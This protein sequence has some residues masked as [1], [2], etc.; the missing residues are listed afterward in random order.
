MP[1]PSRRLVFG[2]RPAR[3]CS[4]SAENLGT[5]RLGLPSVYPLPSQHLS[6]TPSGRPDSSELLF[7]HEDRM[8]EKDT[9]STR[10]FE[11]THWGRGAGLMLLH[12]WLVELLGMRHNERAWKEWDELDGGRRLIVGGRGKGGERRKCRNTPPRRT[13]YR[14]QKTDLPPIYHQ[15]F[16]LNLRLKSLVWQMIVHVPCLAPCCLFSLK[17]KLS[18]TVALR[19]NS[20]Y[21]N[22][23]VS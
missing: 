1:L 5:A 13:I 20:V 16:V 17:I 15:Q 19:N 6:S 22:H 10:I 3:G 8:S 7:W 21:N 12:L 18:L 4:Q 23:L 9:G 2:S 14:A 11:R